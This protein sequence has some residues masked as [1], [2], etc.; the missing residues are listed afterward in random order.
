MSNFEHA[1]ETVVQISHVELA[2][3][4]VIC[5]VALC[6]DFIVCPFTF[7]YK[8][9]WATRTALRLQSNHINNQLLSVHIFLS[10]SWH[11]SGASHWHTVSRCF[12]PYNITVN[13]I[14]VT[15]LNCIPTQIICMKA[16]CQLLLQVFRRWAS[17]IAITQILSVNSMSLV[18]RVLNPFEIS[19]SGAKNTMLSSICTLD[20][21]S[22]P[23]TCIS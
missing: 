9:L 18:A 8:L 21:I 14:M 1:C 11:F 5:S 6:W 3:F 16:F 2:W 7:Q 17:S 15:L 4:P 10:L 20:H 19:C 23:C 13:A 22:L 12:P